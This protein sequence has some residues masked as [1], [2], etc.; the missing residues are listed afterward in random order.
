MADIVADIEGIKP[1]NLQFKERAK[2]LCANYKV[3]LLANEL[4]NSY[5]VLDENPKLCFKTME[6]QNSFTQGKFSTR[7]SRIQ[8]EHLIKKAF[9]LDAYKVKTI[10]DTTGGL[11]HD[12]FILALLGQKVTVV[13]KNI[14]LCILLEEALNA[15]PELPYFIKAKSNLTII[16]RDSREFLKT[17]QNFDVIYVDPMFNSQKKLKRSKQMEFLDSYLDEYDDPSKDFYKEHFQR[18]VVKK[19]LR[20]TTGIKDSSAISFKG[21]SIRYDVY[22]KGEK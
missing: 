21:S 11:G 9:A 10:L 15:L 7:I 18:L 4:T 14:G 2:I 12:A 5:V 22:L 13:E 20:A 6:L 16:N 17:S 19:E 8:T 3:P 1:A